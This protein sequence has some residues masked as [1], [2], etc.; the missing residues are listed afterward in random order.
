M[1]AKEAKGKEK[2]NE[3]VVTG[4]K[5]T[6]LTSNEKNQTE[7]E[8]TEEENQENIQQTL[9]KHGFEI[10]HI[11]RDLAAVTRDLAAVTRDLAAAT[12]RMDERLDAADKKMDEKLEEFKRMLCSFLQ[13][14][15]SNAQG[16][17]VLSAAN[18]ARHVLKEASGG[19]SAGGPSLAGEPYPT[20]RP[21]AGVPLHLSGASSL[22]CQVEMT[23]LPIGQQAVVLCPAK[24][25]TVLLSIHQTPPPTANLAVAV[26][27][28]P[29]AWQM[30]AVSSPIEGGAETAASSKG[31]TP[32]PLVACEQGLKVCPPKL[33]PPVESPPVGDR[34]VTGSRLPL[35][36]A[37]RWDGWVAVGAYPPP[38]GLPLPPLFE[39]E[40]GTLERRL[41]LSLEVLVGLDRFLL[42]PVQDEPSFGPVAFVDVI[43][44]LGIDVSFEHI[45][46]KDN[47]LADSLSRMI[48]VLAGSQPN[49]SK[50]QLQVL[51]AFEQ[52]LQEWQDHPGPPSQQQK[53]HNLCN[54]TI[55]DQFTG[56]NS[57]Q[58][59]NKKLRYGKMTIG[60]NQFRIPYT[61][62][63]PMHL[64]GEIQMIIGC[65]FIRAMQKR[66]R[67]QPIISSFTEE[68][69]DL[70]YIQLQEAV[71]YTAGP[72]PQ[73]FKNKFQPIMEKLKDVG[74]IGEDPLKHWSKNKVVCKI[75][76]KNPD[77]IIED[78]PLKHV[79]PQMKESFEGHI[80]SLLK[81]GVI[82]PSQSQHRTTA[83]IVYSGTTRDPK[84]GEV[85]K[86]KERLVFNY[87]RLNDNTEKDRFA[88]G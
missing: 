81:L 36:S 4:K 55:L 38:S 79:T 21:P 47:V 82:R 10:S 39:A 31:T 45:D 13:Y 17:Q 68:I 32:S 5:V 58:S 60:E 84:T 9:A 75:T 33:A 22:Q 2:E 37:L 15:Q 61:Y 19:S 16:Y 18:E 62:A 25:A 44:G 71:L 46:G 66:H 23:T 83:I 29:A 72:T 51:T 3:A 87:K 6:E 53:F 54:Q 26:G 30:L 34:E 1:A 63:F 20:S 69:D 49:T 12:R 28:R 40:R 77:F 78:R 35:P 65:N 8:Q 57:K 27:N 70:E 11:R 67:H 24:G 14:S 74:Y 48:T 80:T 64:G 85:K 73:H 76:L 59:A 86:G 88:L 52:C 43:T 50:L 42:E 7:I 41:E 56:V